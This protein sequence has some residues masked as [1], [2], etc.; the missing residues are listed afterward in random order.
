MSEYI[1]IILPIYVPILLGYLVRSTGY[2]PVKYG[3]SL[4]QFALKIT[5][6]LLIF[7]DMAGMDA[8]ALSQV[9]PVVLSLPLY[10][11]ILWLAALLV[12]KIPLFR[13]R[14]VETVLIIILGNIGYFGWAVTEIG[15]G[16]GGLSRS[17]MYAVLFWPLTILFS[18][19][20]K[21][22]LDRSDEGAKSAF[23]TLKIAI[24]I[25]LAFVAGLALA[26]FGIHAPDYIME[27][28]AKFGHMTVPLILFGVGLSLSFKAHWGELSLLLPLR[29]VL[30]FGAA[31]LTTR[32]NVKLD[33][34]SR[35]V[36]LMVA[37]MPVA[38]NILMMGNT[39]KLDEEYLSGAIAISS[40]MALVTIPLTLILFS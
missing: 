37:L 5:V 21:I 24:P 15:L 13:K 19:L 23:Y 8:D 30:T 4:L 28:L 7:T 25:F 34:I 22:L 16:S 32:M 6:P 3:N 27:P 36:V 31:W 35:S 18:F 39:L 12:S 38:A 26:I 11:T 33:D 2:F 14:R 10:M 17:I 40:L 29:L 20:T 1:P 9:V